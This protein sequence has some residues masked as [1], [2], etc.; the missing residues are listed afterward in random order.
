MSSTG[1][2]LVKGS[3]FRTFNFFAQ[4]LVA[5]SLMPFVVHSLGD[6]MYGFWT[7][8]GTFI[9]YYGL[10]DFGLSVSVERYIAGAIGAGHKDECNRIF[11]TAFL[12]FTGIG[13]VALLITLILALVSPWFWSNIDDASLF[14]KVALVLGINMAIALPIRVF[15]GI[16]VAQLRFDIISLIQFMSLVLRTS[17]IV[18]ALSL[19]YKVLGLALVTFLSSIPGSILYVYF[20]NK[21]LPFLKL[22]REYWDRGSMKTLLSYSSL[23]FVANIANQLRFNIDVFVISAFISLSAVTHYRIASLMAQYFMSLMLAC[24][25]VFQSLFSQQDGATDHEAIRETL[26]FSTKIS[27]CLSSFIAF[28]FIV[29]GKSFIERW[30]GPGYLDAYPPLC[31]LV[32]GFVCDLGQAPSVF[33]MFATSKHK[34]YALASSIEGISNVLLSILLVRHYGLIGVALGTFISMAVIRL[35]IQPVYFCRVTSIKYSEYI[36]KVSRT[37][38]VVGLSLIIPTIISVRFAAPDYQTLFTLA[39]ISS[40]IYALTIWF[41]EFNP[42]E[43]QILQRAILPKLSR[44]KADL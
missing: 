33:L 40:C 36:Y 21:N 4:V 8:V 34:L 44:K 1:S 22:K 13:L 12:I 25:G 7:F 24:M 15:S 6:R 26:F 10:L 14:S 2:K 42:G 37:I 29:W 11:N 43:K 23:T 30:M 18:L 28:G 9:G 38:A 27:I 17:L 35:A 32:L 3:A 16:L 31:I 20:A 41:I 39:F 19:G 5:F